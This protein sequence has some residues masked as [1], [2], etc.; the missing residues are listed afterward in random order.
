M[1]TLTDMPNDNLPQEVSADEASG[2][3][4]A[5]LPVID[6]APIVLTMTSAHQPTFVAKTGKAKLLAKLPLGD[7]SPVALDIDIGCGLYDGQG[8]CLDV[9]WYGKLRACDDAVRLHGDTFVGMQKD[10]LPTW[11]E[12][13]LSVRLAMLPQQV[14]TVALFLR[15]Q[16]DYALRQAQAGKVILKDDHHSLSEIAYSEF[17][18]SQSACVWQIKRKHLA[19]QDSVQE[20]WQVVRPRQVAVL[21]AKTLGEMMKLWKF[22]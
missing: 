18:D 10:Y 11:V 20:V 2:L 21:G 12:E 1:Q 15:T 16:G 22:D 13:S 4:V 6:N 19:N 9:A 3:V 8:V 7:D 14:Q 17:A 5:N